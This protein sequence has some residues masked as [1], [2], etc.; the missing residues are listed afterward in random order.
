M[1]A[2][3]KILINKIL[4]K[5]DDNTDVFGYIR[6]STP[7]QLEKGYSIP[8]QD[9]IIRDYC[10]KNKYNLLDVF[11]DDA[12]SGADN[13]REGINKALALL[14]PGMK[15]VT[16]EQ[17][18]FTRDNYFFTKMMRK[19]EKKKCSLVFLDKNIDTQDKNTSVMTGIMSVLNENE[20]KMTSER[21][22]RV[23]THM[24]ESGT[25]VCKPRFGY[26]VKDGEIL[27]N[28]EEQKVI[29]FIREVVNI[30]PDI[31]IKFL[32]RLIKEKNFELRDGTDVTCPFICKIIRDNNIGFN[33][34]KTK[35]PFGISVVRKGKK[36]TWCEN[37][38]EQQIIQLI[39]NLLQEN[40]KMTVSNIT[41]FLNSNNITF[42][43]NREFYPAKVSSIIQYYNLRP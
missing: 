17:S 34:K 26:C 36:S 4:G 33:F 11:H 27:E 23:M 30:N 40:P 31:K 6:V 42:G 10:K 37:E 28:P 7:M 22:T 8:A 13:D 21:V 39:K 1:S 9:A 24:S 2:E 43:N 32:V 3:Q 41:R 12:I 18:R 20:R 29:S 38:K 14:K 25:L 35:P 5:K 19:L 15:I 16:V